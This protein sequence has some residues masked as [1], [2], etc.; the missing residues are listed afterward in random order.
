MGQDI[1]SGPVGCALAFLVVLT[2][3]N[4]GSIA[5]GQPTPAALRT[6]AQGE[7]LMTDLTRQELTDRAARLGHPVHTTLQKPETVVER[8][9]TP[10]FKD[11]G[12]YRVSTRPPERPRTYMLGV[13]GKDGIKVLNNDPEAFFELASHGGLEL[14]SSADH[15]AYVTAFIESTRDFMGGPQILKSIDEAWWLP[16]PSPEESR[17]REEVTAKY[18]KVVEGPRISR[19]SGTTVV[20]YMIRD[21]DRAL[22][23]VDAK[24]ESGGRIE[25]SETVLE[26]EMPTVMLR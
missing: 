5:T 8:V 19:D 25:V 7:S 6:H 21:V 22:L 11:G 18:K 10:F 20:V 4:V 9:P 23:R 1:V 12:I 24:V 3:C 2:A 17:K 26:P 14:T 15:V 16:S 13:W